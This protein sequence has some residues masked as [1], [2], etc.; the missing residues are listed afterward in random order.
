MELVKLYTALLRRKWLVIEATVFFTVVAVVLALVL[1]KNYEAS[2]RVWINSSDASLAVLSDLGL[3]EVAAGLNQ[4]SDE[5]SDQIALVTTKPILDELVWRLQLRD[6]DGALYTYDKVLVAGLFGELEARP[7]LEVTQQQGTAVLVFQARADDPELARL[8]ADTAVKVAIERSQ[9]SGREQTRDARHFIEAQLEVVKTEFDQAL[10]NIS[11]AQAA[12]QVIDIESE[13]KAAISRLSEL[14]LEGEQNAAAIQELRAKLAEARGFQE[15]EGTTRVSAGSLT[16][17]PELASLQKELLELRQERDEAL[18]E[19]TAAHPDVKKL[20]ALIAANEAY[21][22][23]ALSRQHDMDPTVEALEASLAGLI[24]K[25]AEIQEGIRRQTETFAAYPDKMRRMS[26][27]ELAADAAQDV[28]KSLE[29]QRYQIGVAEAMLMSNL[30]SIEP[31][32]APDKASSPK[33]LVNLILGMIVGMG[34]GLG[35]ALVFEY[36]DDTIKTPDDLVE[37]WALPR[38]GMIPRYTLAGDR[39][40]IDAVPATDPLFEA[41]RAVRSALRYASLDRPMKVISV[42]SALPGEGKSTVTMNLAIA[43]AREGM[44][45]LVIDA[46]LR[47]PTQHRAFPTISRAVGLTSVLTG[48]SALGE[49]VQATP[50]DGLFLLASGP[51]P[52]DPGRLLESQRF[53]ELLASLREDWD[54]VLVDTPP[55]LVVGDAVG[56]GPLVDGTILVVA[57]QMTSRKLIEDLR[58]RLEA[59]RLNVLGFVLNRINFQ[60][61]GYGQYVKVYKT[62][63]NAAKSKEQA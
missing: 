42:T 46:D 5:V 22:A 60:A 25:G 31:A 48:Q 15:N 13:M 59:A 2:A 6:D 34:V 37:L 33:L 1:P 49:A 14:M 51:T 38:L 53:R 61:A 41:H 54:I 44:R 57:S 45:T 12:E 21:I 30:Q 19:K 16:E 43:M 11:D 18:Q 24:D 56:L 55:S 9:E 62:Y 52:P 47:R 7:N 20:D 63:E 8:M 36:V 3:G 29:E 27:L 26:Q 10:A 40:V 4:S 23:D 50:V 17:N 58:V 32:T 39:R 28:F 35:L